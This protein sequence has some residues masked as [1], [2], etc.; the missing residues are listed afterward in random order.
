MSGKGLGMTPTEALR[1][2]LEARGLTFDERYLR[3]ALRTL[4]QALMETEVSRMLDAGLYERNDS[5][6]AYR[7]GYR[8]SLWRTRVGDITLHV[9]KLRKGSYY[10]LFLNP[11][12]ETILQQLAQ[13]AYINGVEW[14][15]VKAALNALG[16]HILQPPDVADITERL[17]DVV[18]NA[19][20]AR[21]R[22]EY[23]TLFM[24]VLDVEADGY[25]RQ[26]MIV[27]GVQ[28]SGTVDLLA[29]ELVSVADDRAWARLLR[30]LRE[31]GLND[32]ELAISS[33]TAGTRT[34]V[35]DVLVSAVWQHHR[36]FLLRGMADDA[37]VNAVSGLAVRVESEQRSLPRMHLAFELFGLFVRETA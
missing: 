23:P 22:T 7:N 13:D 33:D 31:R 25:W 2:Y 17:A 6:R 5:R 8:A 9:P 10:P 29:H 15:D 12:S 35:S 37:L 24:D 19:H 4:A 1:N 27:L 32:V 30:R 11:T 21:I 28:P 36:N 16:L 14:A 18:H 20:H 26:L 3:E 34:A